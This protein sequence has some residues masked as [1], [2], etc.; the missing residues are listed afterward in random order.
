LIRGVADGK[1]GLHLPSRYIYKE[2][3]WR[4]T[5]R[6][7]STGNWLK[8]VTAHF[9]VMIAGGLAPENVSR[10]VEEVRPWGVDVSS[11]VETN[12]QKDAAK[13][14]AFIKAVRKADKAIRAPG[15]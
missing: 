1:K 12:G 5:G 4:G 3:L 13:I 2:R 11:G 7:P 8:E 6:R 9:P 10:L 15:K 14:I